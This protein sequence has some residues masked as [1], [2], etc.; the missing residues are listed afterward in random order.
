MLNT[1]GQFH[2]AAAAWGLADFPHSTAAVFADLDND[3]DPDLILGRSLA[4]SLVFLNNGESFVPQDSPAAL[5]HLVSSVSVADVNAD[6]LL[7]VYFSTYAASMIERIRDFSGLNSAQ[8]QVPLQGFMPEKEA[9]ILA[10]KIVSAQFH[11]YLERPGPPNRIFENRGG[12]QLVDR[13]PESGLGVFKN[14]YQAAWS[15]V[16]LDGDPDLYLANDF[17]PNTLFINQGHWQFLDQTEAFGVADFG[18][19]MGVSWGDFDR[20]GRFDLYVSNM[21]SRA[22]R[23]ITGGRSEMDPRI[24]KAARGNSLFRNTGSG[25]ERVSG[26]DSGLQVERAGWAWGGQFLDVNNDGLQDLYV[27]NGYYSAPEEA[28]LDRDT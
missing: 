25:F 9:R 28:A 11:F 20:D 13:S 2:S 15:D 18:F 17:S 1:N 27:P 26:V 10:D 6:G 16:D 22:G 23:R 21:Y 3:G 5:P 4:P 8:A 12:G 7:D 14:T 24:Q 19:G